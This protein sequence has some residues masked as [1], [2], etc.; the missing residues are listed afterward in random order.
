MENENL[1]EVPKGW[2]DPGISKEDNK[3]GMVSESSFATLFPKYREKYLKEC[4]PLVKKTLADYVSSY[5]VHVHVYDYHLTFD[6]IVVT[7]RLLTH[8]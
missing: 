7:G 6:F 8:L 2:R 5:T 4:W 3:H 1:L